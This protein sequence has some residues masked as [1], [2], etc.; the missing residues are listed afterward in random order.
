MYIKEGITCTLCCCFFIFLEEEK[1]QEGKPAKCGLKATSRLLA[2]PKETTNKRHVL[3]DNPPAGSVIV[4]LLGSIL[5]GW[6]IGPKLSDSSRDPGVVHPAG[7]FARRAVSVIEALNLGRNVAG[8]FLTRRGQTSQTRWTGRSG[9]TGRTRW[10]G[11]IGQIGR[12]NPALSP[13][14]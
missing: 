9:R 4:F 1:T 14:R 13:A 7:V 8:I 6:M 2:L 5:S 12:I 10:I 3:H 11:R